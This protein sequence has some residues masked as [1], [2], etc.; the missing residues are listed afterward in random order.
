MRERTHLLTGAAAALA[1][2]P[3]LRRLSVPL[4]LGASFTDVDL[5][6]FYV[7]RHRDLSLRRA[8]RYYHTLTGRRE[9]T[10][11]LLHHPLVPILALAGGRR[12]PA[13]AAFGGGVAV[14]LMLDV[15]AKWRFKR[16]RHALELRAAGYCEACQ[17]RQSSLALMEPCYVGARGGDH[18]DPASWRL[19]C[20]SCNE[21]RHQEAGTL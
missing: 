8:F 19:L 3:W 6:A 2:A 9:H 10:R 11:K 20:R 18:A 1:L 4:W 12:C 17:E 5:Y 21:M 13:L 14:H 16:L 15:Y 7:V